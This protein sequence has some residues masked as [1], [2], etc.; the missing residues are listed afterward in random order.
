MKFA[1]LFLSA[2]L[3][4]SDQQFQPQRGQA[5]W[6]PYRQQ[7]FYNKYQPETFLHQQLQIPINNYQPDYYGQHVQDEDPFY[8]RR[9]TPLIIPIDVPYRQVQINSYNAVNCL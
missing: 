9:Y 2:F 1:I 5:W 3:V 7:P 4:I 6:S 8:R